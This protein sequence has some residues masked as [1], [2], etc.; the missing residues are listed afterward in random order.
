MRCIRWPVPR[1]SWCVYGSYRKKTTAVHYEQHSDGFTVQLPLNLLAACFKQTCN[2]ELSHALSCDVWASRS[3][4]SDWLVGKMTD[5]STLVWLAYSLRGCLSDCSAEFLSN[6]PADSLNDRLSKA[7][8]THHSRS[9]ATSSTFEAFS[10][11]NID[12]CAKRH[13][14]SDLPRQSEESNICLPA[15][16]EIGNRT[17]SVCATKRV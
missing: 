6:C 2:I 1:T 15:E 8:A 17:E 5:S 16:T 7:K 13:L 9:Y 11:T 12:I 10:N 4:F 3:Y 14:C